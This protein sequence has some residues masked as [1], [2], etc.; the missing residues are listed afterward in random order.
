ML[1][2]EDGCTEIIRCE[3]LALSFVY[4]L[5]IAKSFINYHNTRFYNII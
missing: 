5:Q 4:T 1:F 2:D 3:M